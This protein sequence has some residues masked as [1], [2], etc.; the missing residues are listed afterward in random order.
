MATAAPRPHRNGRFLPAL[1]LI[2]GLLLLQTLIGG[3]SLLFAFPGYSLIALA[4]L[5]GLV[6]AYRSRSGGDSRCLYATGIFFGYI[7]VR[8]LASPGY[9]ARADTFAALGALAVYGLAICT[10][11]S[12]NVRSIIFAALLSF[13]VVHV[14][15]GMIQ[16]SRGDNFMLLPFLQRTDYEQRA[17][18]FYVCP[19]HLAGLLE[20][21]GIFG[22]SLICWGRWPVWGKVIAG[23]ATAVCYVG[24]ALTG[25]RGGYLSV[26]ASFAVFAVLSIVILRWARSKKSVQWAAIAAVGLFCVFGAAG[27]LMKQSGFLSQRAGNIIDTR[28]MRLELWRA[29]IVQWRLEPLFG[30]GSGTYR[31]YGRKFRAEQMQNDPIDVHND[32]LQLLCEFGVVGAAGF[33]LFFSIHLR[34]GWKNLRSSTARAA[35]AGKLSSNQLAL[36]IGAL[37]ALAAYVVHSIFDFNLHIPA[38]ALLLALVFGILANSGGSPSSRHS[39]PLFSNGPRWAMAILSLILLVVCFRLLP[40]EYFTEKARTAL[41]DEDPV[42]SIRF[43][44][45][46]LEYEN[47][48]PDIFFYLGRG[49]IASANRNEALKDRLPEFEKAIAAFHA[50]HRLAPLDGSY[51]LD[52]AFTYDR[53]GRFSEAER[54]YDLSRDRDPHSAAVSQLYRA[55]LE[56]WKKVA[57][58]KEES[59]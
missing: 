55:H 41:R 23:Y 46:A 45:R 56:S 30:T 1:L 19:N 7:L 18:G 13:A 40:G 14:F 59:M 44:N 22:V 32:Y 52:L 42:E 53:I 38:N 43:A 54:M 50:A 48:N 8:A 29:A 35:D 24:I 4:G 58:P 47:H 3:R 39:L 57:E 21:V 31:F 33:L 12:P 49:I 15:I 37:G 11:T 51:P 16:F 5:V 17:S 28:N 9:F 6:P 2:S 36:N 26:M 27:F 20:V 34:Q 25:S 10:L